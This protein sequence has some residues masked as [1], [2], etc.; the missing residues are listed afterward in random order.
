MPSRCPFLVEY[1]LF[2]LCFICYFKHLPESNKSNMPRYFRKHT[3]SHF[4]LKWQMTLLFTTPVLV[5]T[6]LHAIPSVLCQFET[7]VCIFSQ[8][9]S[10]Y[11]GIPQ[12]WHISSVLI[13]TKGQCVVSFKALLLNPNN[14]W[15][16][17]A[18]SWV[19]QSLP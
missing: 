1:N 16:C 5:S 19:L 3:S 6:L 17:E 14:F 4:W 9:Y 8:I 11:W 18:Y 10:M 12:K 2:S 7:S 15:K 13:Y